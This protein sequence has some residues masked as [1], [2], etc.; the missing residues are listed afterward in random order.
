MA[1]TRALRLAA[2]HPAVRAVRPAPH[3]AD[4][5]VVAEIDI[6]V[7][8]PARWRPAGRSPSGVRGLET[9][10][11][12]FP[13]NFPTWAPS[14]HLRA[15]FNRAHPH[16]NPGP[17]D[18]P[19]QPCIVAGSLSEL[20]QARGFEGFLDQLVDWL[21]EAAMAALNDPAQGW[22]SVRRDHIDDNI[23]IDGS[24]IRSLADPA[25][26]CAVVPISFFLVEET[27]RKIYVVNQC[28]GTLVDLEKAQFGC[29]ALPGGAWKGISVGIVVWA[30]DVE[31]GKPFIVDEYLPETVATIGDLRKRAER[32]GCLA[33]LDA[34]LNHIAFGV[35]SLPF[36]P[37]PLTV[38]LL[39]RRPYDVIGTRSPIELCS[40]LIELTSADDVINEHVGQVRLP[41]LREQLSL[42]ILR[43]V[44]DIA[45]EGYHGRKP[46]AL[47]G[48]GSVG[49]KIAMHMARRGEGPSLLVDRSI[50]APHN[51][52]RHALL[53]SKAHLAPMPPKTRA[54]ADGL[55]S[56]GQRPIA[57][58]SDITDLLN[59]AAG[60]GR[61]RKERLVLNT[62]ASTVVRECLAFGA[63]EDRPLIGEAHLL[64]AGR[65]AYAGFEGPGGNP[66]L[67]DLAAESYR[68][69]GNDAAV[70]Q[71]VFSARTEALTIGQGCSAVTFPM[72]DSRVSTLAAGLSEVV[73][74]RQLA[75]KAVEG[76]IILGLVGEDGLSQSWARHEVQ[77]WV[78][79]PATA[80]GDIE[81][82]ISPRVDEKI[83][84]EIAARPG[85]E[86]GGVIVGRFSQI[87][88]AFQV[89]DVIPAPPDSS[90]SADKF[91]LGT[92][93][94]KSAIGG[95]IKDTGGS[96][97]ALG[98]WH[99]HLIK[100]GP[101]LLD[102]ETA[103]KLAL[104]Q[105]FPVLLLIALPDGYT[106]L[107]A[108]VTH[109]E[110]LGDR[111]TVQERRRSRA[112]G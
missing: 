102:A 93:G 44:S 79:L 98:T 38:T 110:T 51:Y 24:A 18:Q 9:V 8:L 11:L 3:A 68:S 16:I 45:A 19:P 36:K 39:V 4:G 43:S 15:D 54:L 37:V 28:N 83:R 13:G 55:A 32:Y 84:A 14:I 60:R 47:I 109:A 100:S 89:V 17:A 10:T 35:A 61:L 23:V 108:E 12:V 26:G 50:M 97:Y 25:G 90:F 82:R 86:T 92:Q 67:S 20:V 103:V 48:C 81:V 91:I 75:E 5:S 72:A 104:R 46:W 66:N 22:E 7:A 112:G 73:A 52:A 96:L 87:A 49:S 80:P 2:A 77:P 95:I 33:E 88:N 6:A 76:H 70:R 74:R 106:F 41:G 99:N 111:A 78:V 53:P 107:T 63:W 21:D 29:D 105:F 56:L 27:G 69:I 34:K 58:K 62:T 64:G 85:R 42:S 94:L 30:R 59:T 71:E 101:S 57:D 1:T 65:V 31:A 40:Y